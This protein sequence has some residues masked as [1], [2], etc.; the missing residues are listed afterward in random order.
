M[1][2]QDRTEVREMLV[3]ILQG[4]HSDTVIRE[5]NTEKAL[6]KIE[7]HLEKLNGKV[8]EHE[9]LIG[10]L[11]IE[12]VQHLVNCPVAPKVEEIT[13]DINEIKSNLKNE[14]NNGLKFRS[15]STLLLMAIGIMVSIIM[16][17]WNIHKSD[18]KTN[19]IEE[20]VRREIRGIEGISKVTR[21][22]YVKYN[23][24]GLSDSVNVYKIQELL[25]KMDKIIQHD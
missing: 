7:T 24:K 12:G 11:K 1:T 8:Y 15:N 13:K 22:G 17:G 6:N 4:W 19:D 25:E 14:A 9:K 5:T 16:A 20:V 23:D 3:S 2:P 10:Q 18:T 21:G